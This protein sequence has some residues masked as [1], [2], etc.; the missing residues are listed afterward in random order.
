MVNG[1]PIE[2]LFPGAKIEYMEPGRDTMDIE[3]KLK[4]AEHKQDC[5]QK[6]EKAEQSLLLVEAEGTRLNSII[7][8]LTGAIEVIEVLEQEV[9]PMPEDPPD[10]TAPSSDTDKEK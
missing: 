8:R 7:L 9:M 2:A 6:R 1:L 10:P 3:Y 4:L 5:A